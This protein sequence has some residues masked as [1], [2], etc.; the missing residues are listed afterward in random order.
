MVSLRR[1]IT[2]PASNSISLINGLLK[3]AD[4]DQPF[5]YIHN[6]Y[7]MLCSGVDLKLNGARNLSSSKMLA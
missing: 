6:I 1:P 3:K 5:L 4:I 7:I 2:T